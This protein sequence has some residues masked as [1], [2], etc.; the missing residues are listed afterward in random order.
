MIRKVIVLIILLAERTS[1]PAIAQE[2][3]K[4]SGLADAVQYKEIPEG[5]EPKSIPSGLQ[6]PL[7]DYRSKL[8]VNPD[9]AKLIKLTGASLDILPKLSPVDQDR[10]ANLPKLLEAVRNYVTYAKR[11]NQDV[12]ELRAR[13]DMVTTEE[14][15]A[16]KQGIK[17]QGDLGS[18]LIAP[19]KEVAEARAR[20]QL[21]PDATPK[22]IKLLIGRLTDPL[23]RADDGKT[24]VTMNPNTVARFLREEIGYA[25]DQLEQD[26]QVAEREGTANLRIRAWIVSSGT[27]P[28]AVS[29]ENYDDIQVSMASR[30]EHFSAIT[31]EHEYDK[32]N[33]NDI[34]L[35]Q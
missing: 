17:E 28:V 24:D 1:V 22:E 3:A 29:V 23:L 16:A 9:R 14:L 12:T 4:S 8:E 2:W 13:W 35:I 31:N 5:E 20:Q 27:K 10:L 11:I 7:I 30:N 33:S 21:G 18:K 26:A 32:Y 25:N 19:F 15:K 6:L 34:R